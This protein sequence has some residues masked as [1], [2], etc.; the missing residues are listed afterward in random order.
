MSGRWTPAT[1]SGGGLWS[2]ITVDRLSTTKGENI[3]IIPSLWVEFRVVYVTI[4][5]ISCVDEVGECGALTGEKPAVPL[6]CLPTC[7]SSISLK[8][9]KD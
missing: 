1:P 3:L 8:T 6:F 2:V 5:T 7:T 4:S 9:S